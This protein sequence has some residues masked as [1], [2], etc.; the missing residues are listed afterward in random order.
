MHHIIERH[1]WKDP[2]FK[3]EASS[4]LDASVQTTGR[5][6]QWRNFT[7]KRPN[8]VYG[9]HN[10]VI[11]DSPGPDDITQGKCGDC[12]FLASLSALA[13]YPDRIKRIFL[14]QEV[15]DAGC[16]AV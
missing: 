10:F 2:H 12:Y 15:N 4:L 13:E 14:T 9:R 3:A 8:E 5:H 6:Q 1:D 7:W 16:Y 11:Y